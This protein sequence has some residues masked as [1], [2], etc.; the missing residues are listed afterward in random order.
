VYQS[1]NQRFALYHLNVR[2]P[3]NH[4]AQS[5]VSNFKINVEPKQLLTLQRLQNVVRH[6]QV[7]TL[8]LRLFL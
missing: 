4:A 1:L 2:S 3:P 5:P 6:F 7:N 8:K